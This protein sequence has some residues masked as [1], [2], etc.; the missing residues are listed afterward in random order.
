MK[1][2]FT[3]LLISICASCCHKNNENGNNTNFEDEFL[4]KFS[5]TDL[6]LAIDAINH[7]LYHLDMNCGLAKKYITDIENCKFNDYFFSVKISKKDY[8]NFYIVI[9]AHTINLNHLQYIMATYSKDGKRISQ[10][11]LYDED[12][13]FRQITSEIDTN[14]IISQTD[15]FSHRFTAVKPF[16]KYPYYFYITKKEFKYRITDNGKFILIKSVPEE[17]YLAIKDGERYFYPIKPPANVKEEYP[18]D[19]FNVFMPN[20]DT[21]L[22]P[23]ANYKYELLNKSVPNRGGKIEQGKRH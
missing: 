2:L 9:Y 1:K 19:I 5:N 12:Y 13:R 8:L 4:N 3:Y 14:L 16:K 20:R 10:L 7:K 15:L 23:R 21:T 18:E 11:I 6:P 17:D 22:C